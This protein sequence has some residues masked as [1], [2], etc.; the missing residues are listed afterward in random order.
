MAADCTVDSLYDLAALT[1]VK[2]CDVFKLEFRSLPNAVQ[3]DVYRTVSRFLFLSS[4]FY[5]LVTIFGDLL[6][7]VYKI[8]VGANAFCGFVFISFSTPV[9]QKYW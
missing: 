5:G 9:R 7:D 8:S 6:V 2:N 3:C 4:P 1:T